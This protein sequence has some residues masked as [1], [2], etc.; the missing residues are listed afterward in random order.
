M[1]LT[2]KIEE[3]GAAVDAGLVDRE[4]AT[5]Q[6]QQYSD[7]GL[8]LVGARSALD[9]WQTVRAQYAD[10]TMRAELGVAACRAAQRRREG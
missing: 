3:L 1:A 2:D 4:T 9:R 10:I 8:T 7:G 6:L 5:H